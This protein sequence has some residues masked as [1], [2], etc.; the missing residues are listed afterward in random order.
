MNM[1][2]P[3]YKEG[4][5]WYVHICYRGRRY[6]RRCPINTR[7]AAKELE[8]RLMHQLMMGELIDDKKK[9]REITTFREFSE[10]WVNT[11][12]RGNNKPS[13]IENKCGVLKNHLIPFFG[14]MPIDGIKQEKIEEYKALKKQSG[15]APKTINNHLAFI[16]K[17]LNCAIEWEVI[18]Q[19]D[20]PRIKK[21]RAEMKQIEF[22]TPAETAQLIADHS[23]PMWNLMIFIALRTGL[24]F[25]ELLGL[26]WEAINLDKRLL[27]VQESIVRGIVGTPKSG[28]IRHVSIAN[29][30]YTE[31]LHWRQPRG[32]LFEVK[33]FENISARMATN[34][35]H[36]ILK[37]VKL[38]RH[39]NWH[40]FRHTFASHLAMSGIPIP[41]IQKY[42]GHASILMT[43]RYA[44]LSPDV[45]ANSV[46][47]FEAMEKASAQP[48]LVPPTFRLPEFMTHN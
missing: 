36:R 3:V 48:A 19:K 46:N 10:R 40:M 23:E 7:A 14:E 4:P 32:R 16:S 25:G 45:Y 39:T 43:M 17:C 20:M 33:G 38:Q 15:L 44:H 5:S 28:K 13:E 31:L 41:Q 22:L 35:L 29:D 11:H 42:M 12:V 47:C 21:L 26:K 34:A 30:L 6:K 8:L 24:R 9:D 18:E 1:N 2:M 37:R 27:T